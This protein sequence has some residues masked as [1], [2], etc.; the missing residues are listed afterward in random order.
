MPKENIHFY[1]Y[2]GTDWRALCI[3]IRIILIIKQKI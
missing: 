2:F 3:I 1:S